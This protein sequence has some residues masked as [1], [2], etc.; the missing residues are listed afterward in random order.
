M[1]IYRWTNYARGILRNPF[2]YET[3]N[4]FWRNLWGNTKFQGFRTKPFYISKLF[5]V[6]YET[7][8]IAKPYGGFVLFY[9]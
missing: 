9:G 6:F 2:E 8:D 4:G 7:L 1:L 3:Q 5:E